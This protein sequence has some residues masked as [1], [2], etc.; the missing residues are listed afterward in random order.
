MRDHLH[1]LLLATLS[2]SGSGALF[3]QMQVQGRVVDVQGE[4]LAFANILLLT[5]ADSTFVKGEVSGEDGTFVFAGMPANDYRLM[6]SMVGYAELYSNAFTLS[7]NEHL[8][9]A[10]YTL[11]EN[12]NQLD[13]VTVTARKPLYEQ[14]IDRLVIN[15]EN[16]IT[17]AGATALDVLERSPGVVV[18]RQNNSIA[19]AGKNGVIVMING[20]I[21]RM[22]IE[23]V[24]Q[25]LAGMPSGNIEKIELITTP[26]ANFDAEG[27]AGFINIVMKQSKD[28]GLNGGYTFSGGIGRSSTTSA[29]INFNYRKNKINLYGD[30]SFGRQAQEQLFLFDGQILLN[31]N[32]LRTYTR[33]ERDPV[34]RN[35]N[36]S[37]G[38]DWTLSKKTVL[39]MLLSSYDNRWSMDAVNNTT[40]SINGTPD[41][42]LRIVNDEINHWQ[43]FGGNLNLQHTIRPD[44]LLT[45]DLDF[46]AYDNDN[47]TNYLTSYSDTGGNFLFEERTF[48]GKVT[49]INVGVGKLDYAK[50]FS[51]KIK[52]ELGLKGT[53]SRFDNDVTVFRVENAIPVND[54]TLTAEYRLEESIMA[55]YTAFDFK[56]D[57]KSDA[58]L[59]L[60]YEYTNSNLGTTEQANIVD[61][62]YGNFFPSAFLSRSFNDKHSA[63]FSYSR[64]ISRPT[65]NDM[66]PFVI[67][68]DPYTFFSGNAALQPSISNN[69]KLDY[70][71]GSTLFSVQYTL[72]DS[73][74]AQF[75]SRVIEGTNQQ[76]IAAENLKNRNTL[77]FTLA[78]PIQIA[79]WWNMQNNIIGTWQE[80]NVYFDET[81][82]NIQNKNLQMTWINSFTLPK[83]FRAELT[84]F[85]QTKALFGA[86][87]F[88]P[89]YGVNVGVQK[90]IGANGGTLR[91]GVD[92]V[93]NSFRWRIQS[94]LPE[95]N[96]VS[97]NEVDF[98][99][100]TFK[101][102]YSRNF[103]NNSLEDARQRA[104]GSEEERRR[105]N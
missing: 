63:N 56:L 101:L 39:G 98:S 28:A 64:R 92:D 16:S 43:H 71:F 82:V 58:K 46:L 51:D 15:V 25:M 61:R 67:F 76:L 30:Y 26:P 66:A 32:I 81:L 99:Q 9:L 94:D 95:Y 60:R 77:A 83:D 8:S 62:Q 75:Q 74:I 96:L 17:A 79:E 50:R 48:S 36:V 55:A 53:R 33:S 52:M 65:F 4:P 78:L 103:G 68:I 6:L 42:L 86:S 80:V 31:E 37:L 100:R 38:L 69:V 7:T 87:I 57:A 54:P 89:V 24:V 90:K 19:L 34:Q 45:F 91:F 10:P 1:L 20:R 47:P 97:S 29:G 41:T 27:N 40:I 14:R 84:G 44:E 5:V 85:Y 23:A 72:E 59:G 22:P 104:T 70:R 105:V 21:N 49:P 73:A 13:A 35:H 18:N 11:L 3:A 2:L 93:L 88:L 12:I 102:S